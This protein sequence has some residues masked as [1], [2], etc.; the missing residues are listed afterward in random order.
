[1]KFARVGLVSSMIFA[2][3]LANADEATQIGGYGELHYNNIETPSSENPREEIDFHRFVV[4]LG[5][6]FS[7]TI[8]FFSEVEIE[9]ALVEGGKDSGEVEIEQAYIEID[10]KPNLALTA[11]LFLLPVGIINETHEPTVFYG[12]ERNQVERSILP[13]TWWESGV[14]LSGLIGEQGFSYDV[15]VHSGLNGGTN[16]RNGRQKSSEA[17]AE[18][19]AA[20][21]RLK[22]TGIA[23]LELSTT[24]QVQEDLDQVDG[25]VDEG[26]LIEMH[27]IYQSGPLNL[28]ALYARWDIDGDKDAL[29]DEDGAK[30][31]VQQG[32]YLESSYKLADAVGVF[33][34][35]S[36]WEL[37]DKKTSTQTD[38]GVNY[39][40]HE[41]VVFKADIQLQNGDAG[42]GDGFN[43]G[44][45]YQF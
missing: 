37:D 1:M 12:V 2:G 24:L 21:G 44:I 8:R 30:K 3:A 14:M 27:G 34:R 16:I 17:N 22:F 36:Q 13:A 33:A 5:H 28:R 11:G 15:A 40:P 39:W 26:V 32:F 6:E 4:F 42:N 45:G 19:K 18:S 7:D 35:F 29:E 25:G 9:H 38:I 41:D 20:T 23:G 43:L 31:D 10:L